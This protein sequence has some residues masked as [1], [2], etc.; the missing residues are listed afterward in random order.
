[1]APSLAR[2]KFIALSVAVLGAISGCATPQR[3]IETVNLKNSFDEKA[4][5]DAMGEGAS[6][7]QGSA[8]MRQSGGGVVTCAGLEVNLVPV[9][10]YSTER[11]MHIYGKV[12]ASGATQATRFDQLRHIN[13]LPDT[14]AAYKKLTR[15]ALCDAQGNFEFAG[16]KP[17]PFYVISGIGW[18][19]GGGG[20][21]RHHG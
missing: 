8:L 7:L 4:T 13:F 16:L 14:E 12:P 3:L 2:I 10:A 9:T 5:A 19:V 1:M 21:G 20:S 6:T 11:L 17:G 18:Q 15:S